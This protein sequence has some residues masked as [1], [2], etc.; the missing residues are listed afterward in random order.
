MR[1]SMCAKPGHAHIPSLDR[2]LAKRRGRP[3]AYL[4]TRDAPM[5]RSG[6]P[7]H[8]AFRNRSLDLSTPG[9]DFSTRS[10]RLE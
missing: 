4:R 1:V 6:V 5:V 10:G 9:S 8:G 7:K 2:Q 3:G